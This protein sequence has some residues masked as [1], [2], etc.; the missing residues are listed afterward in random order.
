MSDVAAPALTDSEFS[1]GS[2]LLDII[3][4][5]GPDQLLLTSLTGEEG[6][7]RLFHFEVELLSH[8]QSIRAEDLVGTSV[9]L[10]IMPVDS[11]PRH[12]HG[13]VS[14]FSTGAL[15]LREFRAYRAEVVPWLWF[16]SRSADCRI[17]Q[18]KCIP[19]IVKEVF[20]TLG[21]TDYE[22]YLQHSPYP[23]LEYCVQYRETALN[24]VSRLMEQAGLFYFF[25]HEENKH[26]LVIA[27]S[28]TF[29]TDLEE[30]RFVFADGERAPN[31]AGLVTRWEHDWEFKTGRWAQTDYDFE[32]P[33]HSLLTTD[34]TVLTFPRA[35]NF[36]R[37]DY[38]GGYTDLQR[39]KQLTRTLM[40]AEEAR[41]HLVRGAT[42]TAA[43][44]P[45]K[46]FV[47][48]SHAIKTEEGKEYA[49]FSVRHEAREGSYFAGMAV[50]SH[51]E[52]S[53]EAIDSK[54]P[55]RPYRMTPKPFV[56]GP[57][58]A[59]VVGPSGE[60][61]YT[62]KYGRVKLQFRWDRQGKSDD[63]SSCWVRVS[64]G[65]AGAGWGGVN[66]PHVG[67]EV[68]VSFL[69]GDP[70]RPLV[71]GRVYNAE[72]MKAMKLPENKTQSSIQDH[73]GNYITM[74]GKSGVQDVRVNAVK[75]MNFTVEHDYNDIVKSGDRTIQ[76]SSGTHTETIKGDTSITIVSGKL[77]IAVAAN[78]ADY[79]SKQD[80][81]IASTAA[82]VQVI[83]KESILLDVGDS[84]LHMFKTG[85]IELHGKNITII[86]DQTVK[87]GGNSITIQGTSETKIGVGGQNTLYN[88][89]EVQ[90][91]GAGI[92]ST[93]TGTHNITG[94]VVKI[95]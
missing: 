30:S 7:S 48:G 14:R 83:A 1:R 32:A 53:F 77:S 39:G 36:E 94:A 56:Q 47:L 21:F 27:D 76:I 28:N 40:E 29:F 45:G 24:F 54:V 91:S 79:L 71:T 78:T 69:E 92:S 72:N 93:A 70:D 38:P 90:T 43:V 63:Q 58:T 20:D 49:I 5:L 22:F 44:A 67:H 9:S 68:V 88:T 74:E 62:D 57:Q 25:K 37:F 33:S 85:D 46:K 17:F 10:R 6:L 89:A 4:K 16:L 75:D 84:H 65:W 35:G 3:T 2:R 66:I 51:Y 18:H 59:T 12:L 23:E 50:E 41:Y 60:K 52:N 13:Y 95:N 82:S 26:I 19:D 55:H 15:V 86:G 61:I 42:A 80:T 64:Q 81:T 8:D 11:K 34:K 31:F 73:T 87:V